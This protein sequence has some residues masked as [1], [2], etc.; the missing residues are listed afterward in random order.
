MTLRTRTLLLC[1]AALLGMLLLAAISLS[2]LRQ[3]M[4]NERLSQLSTLVELAHASL[5]KLHA[6]ETAGQLS[7]EQAQQEARRILGSLRKNELYFW[8]RGYSS[9]I[10]TI[11]PNAKRVGIVDAK[12]GKEAGERYRAALNGQRVGVLTAMGTRPGSKEEVQKLYAVI[13]FEP[14][15]WIVGTGDYIDDIDTAFWRSTSILLAVGGTLMLVVGAMGWRMARSLYRQLGGEPAYAADIVRKIGAGDLRVRVDVATGDHHSL[16]AAMRDMQRNL[17]NTVGH[18][19]LSADTIA[20]ASAE[21]AAGNQ[22]LSGRTE[23][24]AS[25]LQQTAASMEELTATVR[26]NADNAREAKSLAVSASGVAGKGG[27]VVGQ[28]VQT[29]AA[30]ST[31]SQKIVDIIGVI[32]GIAFQTNILALNASVE[33]A[34]AGEQGRGFAV[35]ASEVRGLAQRSAAAAKEIK[36]LIDDSARNVEAGSQLVNLAGSTMD[37]VVASVKRV[38]DIVG[39][40]AAASHEQSDGIEQING[41]VTQMDQATQ[42][43]SALVEQASAAAA[44]LRDQAGQLVRAVSTFSIDEGGP[45]RLG[46]SAAVR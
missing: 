10:N 16:L 8:A 19:R 1:G 17:Q 30:I 24:Q 11:H 42:Q 12:G 38:T 31:S 3:T 36:A 35:V 41:A 14:W 29:M 5:D 45:A 18:I 46:R 40:I 44:S 6:Q 13:R 23:Q 28:V 20:T 39:E 34:R 7:R 25:A 9:D 27:D 33:A 21:I 4:M 26:Q 15:D 22:D 2:T 43:N 32:D 37:D